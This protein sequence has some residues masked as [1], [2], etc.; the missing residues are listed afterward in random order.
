[1]VDISVIVIFVLRKR[2]LD[3]TEGAVLDRIR[4]G[5]AQEISIALTEDDRLQEI[6]REKRDVDNFAVGNIYY[7]RVKKVM[8]ALNAVFVDVGHEKE[9]FLH[10]LD[11]GSQFLT[12]RD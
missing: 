5:L 2:G 3:D 9:A 12:L 4:Q 8:P 6:T 11:L 1:M 7:G 10:Y